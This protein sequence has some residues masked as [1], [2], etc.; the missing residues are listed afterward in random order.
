MS[1]PAA[2]SSPARRTKPDTSII[3]SFEKGLLIFEYVLEA[4]RPLKLH[5]VAAHFDIDKA[6]AFRFLNTLER[7]ALVIKD[8]VLKTYVPGPKL[9]SWA[10]MLRPDT[11]L[12]D[13]A[14]P[15][16]KKLSV[17]TKQTSHLAVLQNDRVVLIEVMP[18]DNIVSVKQSSGDWEPLY[19]T[20]V[21]KA[22]MAFLPEGERNRLIDQI[23]FREFTPTTLTTPEMLRVE[24]T[25]VEKEKLAYDDGETNSQ[26]G[27][28]AAPIFDTTRYPVA[29]IGISMIYPLFPEGPKAQTGF[30]SA[31]SQIAEEITTAITRS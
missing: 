3:Q 17:M 24:L 12:V 16:L 18:A 10:R 19:C 23:T 22:I 8:P 15:F 13:T 2:D 31:V 9:G 1:S 29:S 5:E 7:A 20:A 25:E 26:L 30:I 6:S 14:R 11:S 4:D 28:I 27:C 21:G